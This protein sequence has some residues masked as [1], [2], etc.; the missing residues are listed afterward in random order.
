MS[1][2][3]KSAWQDEVPYIAWGTLL[4]LAIYLGGYAITLYLAVTGEITYYL[5]TPIFACLAYAGFTL[6]HDA[7]HGSIF[8]DNCPLKPLE[9]VIGWLA[10]VPLL[11]VPFN[12]FKILHDRHHA[13]T[14]DPELDPDHF[15]LKDNW[16]FVI[17]NCLYIP[18][19]YHLLAFTKL[20]GD[21]KIRQT[22]PTTLLYFTFIG[23]GLALLLYLGFAKEVLYFI[24][25]PNLIAVVLLALFFDYLPHHPH[26][27]LNRYQ[28]ARIYP[29]RILN[30]LLLGQNYHLSHHLYPKVPWY[31]YRTVY[32]KVK[33]DL[34]ANNAPI[35]R[36]RLNR[37]SEFL[38]ST[39][40]QKLHNHDEPAKVVLKIAAIESLTA[41]SV[42]ITF[43]LPPNQLLN[44]KAG[45]YITLSKWLNNTLC[46]RS[47][48]LCN[49]PTTPTLQI[50]VKETNNGV[51]SHYL[52]TQAKVGQ[53]LV[54]A[55]PFGDFVYPPKSILMNKLILI[56]GGSGITP[57]LSI[58]ETALQQEKPVHIH[59]IY[60]CKST[61]QIMF[62]QRLTQ[63][64]QT[65]TSSSCSFNI[66]YIIKEL[67]NTEASTPK[68]LLLSST[69]KIIT[70]KL[71]AN[72]LL[73]LLA[74]P[75]NGELKLTQAAF[76]ICGSQTLKNTV[77]DVLNA[78]NVSPNNIH[79][80]QFVKIAPPAIGKMHHVDIQ[81]INGER[82]SLLVASNQTILESA[83][84]HNI[85]MSSACSEGYCGSCKCKINQGNLTTMPESA[86]GIS[87]EE[88]KKGYTLACQGKPLS[89][90]S[91]SEAHY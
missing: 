24:V 51:M 55:G 84:A 18:V 59:L 83:R 44:F 35:E 61:H 6:L 75:D 8:A 4:L 65:H 1:A 34:I 63:L 30:I 26:V 52:N 49:S 7:G 42:L 56:A 77:V 40:T 89:D 21:Q 38:K 87:P 32:L 17:L 64:L 71:N 79:I 82:V 14:N 67:T 19:Q 41:D 33:T 15:I 81:L 9:R 31:K 29:S 3:F 11:M 78:H 74:E 12:L 37:S 45:Q 48:S 76:Y 60:C 10:G 68:P 85:N 50:A 54:V 66:T 27:S 47:Y 13:Y 80:E 2:S 46:T 43:K 5:A 73:A 88:I 22:Y 72:N 58:V 90:V 69:A 39:H 86:S 70:G 23:M 25:L 62:K 28:N 53:E 57:I 16:F 36:I 91:L 20:S